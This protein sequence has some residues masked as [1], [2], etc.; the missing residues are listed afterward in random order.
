MS[1]GPVSRILLYSFEDS[2]RKAYRDGA[3]DEDRRDAEEG[4]QSLVAAEE[5]F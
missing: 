5:A 1:G 4:L 3:K 2:Y